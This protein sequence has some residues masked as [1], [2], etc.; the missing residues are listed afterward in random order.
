MFQF[1]VLVKM[2][3]YIDYTRATYLI[4]GSENC[5]ATLLIGVGDFFSTIK[6]PVGEAD[7]TML[8]LGPPSKGRAQ[9]SS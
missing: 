1:G 5:A 2:C 3:T 9:K 7:V 8:A 4:A 6:W